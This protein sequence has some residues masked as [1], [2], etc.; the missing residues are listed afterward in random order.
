MKRAAIL[1]FFVLINLP[2]LAQILTGTVQEANGTPAA[3]AAIK[4][5][6]ATDSSF[7]TGTVADV[8]GQYRFTNV[9]DGAYRIQASLIGMQNERSSVVTVRSGQPLTLEPLKL[10][11]ANQ[12]LTAVTVRARKPLI[13]QQI[14]KTVLNVSSD[15]SAQGKTAYELLQQAPGVVIDPND[16]IQMAGKQG[17][18][19]FIDGKPTNLSAADLVNLLRATPASSIDQVELITNPSARYDAQGGAGIINIK[20]RRDKTLGLNGSASGGY[21]QSD[22]HRA[23]AA[24]DLNFRGKRVNLFGNAAVSN[25]FQ[26]TNVL[27]DRYTTGSRFFQR[28]YDSDGTQAVIYK[29]GIDYFMGRRHTLGLIITG[30]SASNQF[31]TY[32][33]T[34]IINNRG[35]L[36]SSI[37]NQVTNPSRANRMNASLNYQYTDT[38]GL[39][40][41]FDADLIRFGNTSPNTITSDYMNQTAE[42]LLRRRYRFDARTDITVKTVKGDLVKAWKGS[43]TELETGFKYT[44]VS[45]NNDLLAFRGGGLT[46][47]P[48]Q[49]DRNRTNRFLYEE[50]VDAVYASLKQ[51][52]G[53]KWTAQAGLRAEH[54]TVLGQSTSL[55]DQVANNKPDTSYLNL[56]PT[57]FVQYQATDKSQ[58]SVKYGRRIGRPNYQDLNP[59]IYQVDPYTSQ[60]GNPFLRPDYTQNTE[61]SYT[62]KQSMTVALGYSHTTDFAA[63]VIQ[64]QNLV[65]YQTV[66]N[67]GQIDAVN[68]SVNAPLPIKKW[69]NGY[70]YASATWNHFQGSLSPGEPF[71][72]RA[73]AFQ[74]YMQHSFTLSNQWNAQLS[75]FW[76]APTTQT[77]YRIGGLGSVNMSVQKKVLNGRGNVS[78]LVDDILNQMRYRQTADFG[79]VPANR[80]Q[81]YIDRK[82]ESR[83]VSVRFSYR[84]GSQTVK[85]TRNRETGIDAGRIKT[86][87]NL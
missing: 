38:L 44:R 31:G 82:W 34:D 47:S 67:V 53:R 39:A 36:D 70:M 81:F 1:A 27:N 9:P 2:S 49:A 76:N 22:H 8:T 85:E 19:V 7:V 80:Q 75:G 66:A 20:R 6:R 54:A 29:A 4:L 56:F 51:P 57:A 71:D 11:S 15:A 37:V 18:I 86:K 30:N 83:R 69:W 5:L 72:Q 79:N 23:N 48:E 40:I 50:R 64:Q 58:F 14:D 41:N 3:F 33:T 87:S 21:G 84:F 63:D 46:G 74:A 73:F 68:V 59:F 43:R 42:V 45:T 24:I 13:E 26:I 28:G 10:Q 32:T 12:T 60:R 77:I 55:L 25:N 17:A 16:N 62:Y 52:I 61:L 35:G 78:L 65:A